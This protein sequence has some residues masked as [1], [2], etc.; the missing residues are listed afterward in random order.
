M[1]MAVA[2]AGLGAPSLSL[3]QDED[4]PWSALAVD[5]SDPVH[6]GY[7]IDKPGRRRAEE[8]ALEYCNGDCEIVLTFTRLCGAYAQGEDGGYGY[9]R[10]PDRETA[11]AVALRE[12]SKHD[13]ACRIRVW[14]C[15]KQR[16]RY[17]SSDEDGPPIR[18][19]RRGR[20]DDRDYVPP[21]PPPPS[22][23][24]RPDDERYRSARS[25]SFIDRLNDMQRRALAF[26]CEYRYNAV[27]EKLRGCLKGTSGN[28]EAA[29]TQGC[30]EKYSGAPE[31]L[32]RCLDY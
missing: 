24:S 18:R 2:V 31:K 7:A 6:Y 25:S 32:R 23:Y 10:E 29:L 22:Y 11:Q 8:T 13:R 19:E 27:P 15:S 28:Y 1:A 4:G 21:P 26:G 17:Q 16:E 20:S 14:A 12:C 9:A 5:K 30:Q 3:A